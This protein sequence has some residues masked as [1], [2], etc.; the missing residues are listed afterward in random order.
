MRFWYSID[1]RCGIAV[2]VEFLRGIAGLGT[3]QRP[4]PKPVR[5]IRVSFL[6]HELRLAVMLILSFSLSFSLSS[7]LP[8]FLS[9]FILFILFYLSFFFAKE[10][11]NLN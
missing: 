8:S 6:F 10:T 9:F 7:F 3:P 11:Q 2:F 1:F 5:H 4:R